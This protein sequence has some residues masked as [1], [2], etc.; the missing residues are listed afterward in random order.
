MKPLIIDAAKLCSFTGS[1]RERER[2]A[3][4]LKKK[5]KNNAEAKYES[6][7]RWH[8]LIMIATVISV[9]YLNSN[10]AAKKTKAYIFARLLLGSFGEELSTVFVLSLS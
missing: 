5:K 6:C 1:E 2:K 7:T 3:L 9:S 4:S 8:F 10:I